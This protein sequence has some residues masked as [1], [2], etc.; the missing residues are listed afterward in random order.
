MNKRTRPQVWAV[1]AGL[2]IIWPAFVVVAALVMAVAWFAI[3]FM[4]A[5]ITTRLR[6]D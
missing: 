1:K 5:S 2:M 6:K 4:D 3:P